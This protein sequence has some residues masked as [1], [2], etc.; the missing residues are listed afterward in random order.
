MPST[1][2]PAQPTQPQPT[3]PQL[4]KP[5]RIELVD[6][7][8][9]FALLGIC[10]VHFME[11]FELYWINQDPTF[12]HNLIF[13]TFGGK[14]YAIFA[15]M[16][17]L[18][19]FI[20]R[21]NQAKKGVDF[22][23]RFA[24]RLVVLLIIGYIHTLLYLGDILSVLGVI[25]LSLLFV[26]K[27]NNRWL[28]FAASLCILQLPFYYQFYAALNNWPGA[29]DAPLHWA[30]FPA[31]YKA[32]TQASFS[33]LL[34]INSWQG[35][36][37][38]WLFFVESGRGVQLVGLFIIGLVLGRIG[39][40]TQVE[41]F[42][43]ARLVSLVVALLA[44]GIFYY[45]EGALKALPADWLQE[46]G[47]AKMYLEQIAGSYLSTAITASILL[48]FMQFYLWRPTEKMAQLL[49]PCGRI[50]LS[51]YLVQSVVGVPLF[52]PA[53][54]GGYLTLGQTNSLLL[55]IAFYGILIAAAHW[56]VKRFHYGPVEWVWR[57]VT[58]LTIQVPFKRK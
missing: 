51:I 30:V 37:A 16:F 4:P 14:A 43:K 46:K 45:L 17:G 9:G 36:T 20:I 21:D 6:A 29:N 44:T 8:R 53:G 34:V 47:T 57:S 1:T 28:L 54:Y 58:Y 13:F 10:L 42:A 38:K 32:I 5:Q 23:Y 55:G 56:W 52:Y 25:G 26:Q 22:S 7:I 27:L 3:L 40:F 35:L 15:L 11:Y 50:S 12:L 18:S 48:L 39:F 31:V 24:W 33:E 49:A 41:R 2:S 19:F